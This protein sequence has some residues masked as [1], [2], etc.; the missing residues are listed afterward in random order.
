MFR[1]NIFNVSIM[2]ICCIIYSS[3]LYA[4]ERDPFI[5]I[6]DLQIE[7]QKSTAKKIDLSK[8]VLKG[9]IWNDSKA[10]AIIDDELVMAG[11]EWKGLKVERIDKDSVTLSDEIKSYKLFI[12]GASLEKE[13]SVTTAESPL[14]EGY[15]PPEGAIPYP[16]GVPFGRP[17]DLSSRNNEFPRDE[18]LRPPGTEVPYPKESR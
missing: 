13:G 8:V 12:E 16:G 4:E 3:H 6:I 14:P 18:G 5:S 1:F 11:D 9:I 15:V 10:V 2:I 17:G 7:S